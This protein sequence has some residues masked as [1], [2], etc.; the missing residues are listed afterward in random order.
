MRECPAVELERIDSIDSD[1][2]DSIEVHLSRVNQA[3]ELSKPDHGQIVGT[4]KDLCEC[5]AKVIIT[6][7]S[8]S[9]DSHDD[10]SKLG[11]QVQNLIGTSVRTPATGND[12][13]A[14]LERAIFNIPTTIGLTRNVVGAGHGHAVVVEL[15]PADVA[16]IVG[17]TQAWC[18]WALR[19]AEIVL[20]NTVSELVR[21]L[22]EENFYGGALTHWLNLLGLDTLPE[23]DQHRLGIAVAAR[24]RNGTFVVFNEGVKPLRISPK[25]WPAEYRTGIAE[26]LL[27]DQSGLLYPAGIPDLA[28]V[29]SCMTTTAAAALFDRV[30]VTPLASRLAASPELRTGLEQELKLYEATFP[31]PT[32]VGWTRLR[33]RLTINGTDD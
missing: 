8:A 29:V 9:P 2:W 31:G 7:V 6:Q 33:N 12:P 27:F 14:Q 3:L 24:A 21:S 10:L 18:S 15:D 30:V 32:R 17:A 22:R 19:R 23:V 28:A 16:L 26:G 25:E 11:K 1:H 20:R 13:L 5:I 4:C